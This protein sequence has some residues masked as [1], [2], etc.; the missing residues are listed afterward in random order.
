MINS[1]LET[2]TGQLGDAKVK[3]LKLYVE[4]ERTGMS[5]EAC[6]NA[7]GYSKSQLY[8]VIRSLDGAEY[9][10]LYSEQLENSG[11]HNNIDVIHGEPMRVSETLKLVFNQLSVKALRGEPRAIETLLKF[12]S[13]FEQLEQQN[14]QSKQDNTTDIEAILAEIDRL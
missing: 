5:A 10:E 3:M 6:A 8:N 14:W 12:S 13:V 7:A 11:V 9:L 4:R 2:L 1:R